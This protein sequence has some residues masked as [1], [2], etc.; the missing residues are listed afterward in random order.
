MKRNGVFGLSL[1]LAAALVL[2]VAPETSTGAGGDAISAQAPVALVAGGTTTLPQTLHLDTSPP[3]AD[4][5]LAFDTTGSMASAITDAE[6]DAEGIVQGVQNSIPNARF[7]L[8]DFKDYP[9]FPFGTP[10]T[11]TAT[12]HQPCTADGC[13]PFSTS[14]STHDT[15]TASFASAGSNCGTLNLDFYLDGGASPVAS[16]SVA[17]NA[18]TGTIN[19]GPTSNAPHTVTVHAAESCGGAPSSWDGTL[20]LTGTGDYPYKLVQPLDPSGTLL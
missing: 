16:A 8:A 13:D 17:P 11:S 6:T 9:T 15:L 14:I 12:V 10:P 2:L 4:V 3:A 5:L 19:L 18:S 20:T 7:A 1:A